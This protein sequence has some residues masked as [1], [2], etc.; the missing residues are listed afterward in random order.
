[1]DV[2]SSPILRL[3]PELLLLVLEILDIPDILH[4][5]QVS[6]KYNLTLSVNPY[7]D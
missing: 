7:E 4:V 2:E 6:S 5:R 1:M 3:P